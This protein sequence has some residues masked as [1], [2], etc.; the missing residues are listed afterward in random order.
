MLVFWECET[1]PGCCLCSSFL[2]SYLSYGHNTQGFDVGK[3]GNLLTLLGGMFC[4]PAVPT[5]SV[6]SLVLE[7]NCL[8]YFDSM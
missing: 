6:N 1:S 5:D 8:H 2:W 4:R 3:P 7:V